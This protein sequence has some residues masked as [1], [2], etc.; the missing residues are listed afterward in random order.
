M[1]VVR[2][3]MVIGSTINLGRGWSGFLAKKNLRMSSRLP[4]VNFKIV[5]TP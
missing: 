2:K 4:V 3:G 5:G 1:D